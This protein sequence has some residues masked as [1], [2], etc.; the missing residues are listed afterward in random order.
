MTTPDIAQNPPEY[1]NFPPDQP[2]IKIPLVGA[3]EC[4]VEMLEQTPETRVKAFLD[5]N[6]EVF[7]VVDE[8]YRDVKSAQ[9]AYKLVINNF[10]GG[11]KDGGS[12]ATRSVRRSTERQ[13]REFLNPAVAFGQAKYVA[14]QTYN[15]IVKEFGDKPLEQQQAE[16]VTGLDEYFKIHSD[17]AELVSEDVLKNVEPP[18]RRFLDETAKGQALLA[19]ANVYALFRQ[20]IALKKIEVFLEDKS[21]VAAFVR[22]LHEQADTPQQLREYPGLLELVATHVRQEQQGNMLQTAI[23]RSAPEPSTKA[24]E[25]LQEARENLP[26]EFSVAL[27]VMNVTAK[28]VEHEYGLDQKNF[29]RLFAGQVAE[30]PPELRQELTNFVAGETNRVWSSVQEAL[31]PFVRTGRLPAEVAQKIIIPKKP[32]R[33][34]RRG[35][36]DIPERERPTAQKVTLARIGAGHEDLLDISGREPLSNFAVLYGGGDKAGLRFDVTPVDDLEELFELT[37]L[38]DY[39]KRHSQDPTLRSVLE[40][41]I[42]HLTLTPKDPAFTESLRNVDYIPA[43]MQRRWARR[44]SPQHFPGISKGEIATKTRIIYDVFKVEGRP[45]LVIYGAFIKGDVESVTRMPRVR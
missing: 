31:E 12:R 7:Q 10:I 27:G 44:F 4:Q 13:A 39:I 45:T 9:E 15:R 40:A 29:L 20:D 25:F 1:R 24:L 22:Q 33:P 23:H 41:A 43:G 17:P 26:K 2:V 6:A 28:L 16:I 11:N 36:P 42:K 14:A 5:G 30:W 34:N 8:A 37:N 32:K 19:V 3:V 21:V 18:V 35:G 38:N